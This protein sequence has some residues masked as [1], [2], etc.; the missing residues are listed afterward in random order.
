MHAG[1]SWWW[2]LVVLVCILFSF[3]NLELTLVKLEDDM[4]LE[5][6]AN[7]FRKYLKD[8]AKLEK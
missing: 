3:H 7:T 5:Q 8:I 1:G 4:M 2:Y 6:K